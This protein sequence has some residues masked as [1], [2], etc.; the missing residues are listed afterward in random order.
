MGALKD[1]IF[2]RFEELRQGQN[3]ELE[4][5]S[6]ETTRTATALRES[7]QQTR[8]EAGARSEEVR[9]GLE[10]IVSETEHKLD[11]H[12]ET[13]AKNLTRTQLHLQQLSGLINGVAGVF[14]E[15]QARE[16]QLPVGAKAP[17]PR[18]EG[19]PGPDASNGRSD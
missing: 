10:H 12:L 8:S 9:V 14:S 13:L 4:E 16:P 11:A 15:H 19:R 1:E 17:R 18:S 5:I 3:K 2:S 6:A 7:L